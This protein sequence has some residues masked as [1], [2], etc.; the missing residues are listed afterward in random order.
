MGGTKE[1]E[2]EAVAILALMMRKFQNYL[3]EEA[4]QKEQSIYSIFFIPLLPT[5]NICIEACLAKGWQRNRASETYFP[6][7]NVAAG[8]GKNV[9]APQPSLYGSHFIREGEAVRRKEKNKIALSLSQQI[10]LL[11]ERQKWLV[12]ATGMS[13]LV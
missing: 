8:S 3:G 13:S 2:Q 10:G 4:L 7:A 1:E 5:Q 6:S 12:C 11:E 9:P